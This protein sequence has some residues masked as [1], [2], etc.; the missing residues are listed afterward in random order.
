M[1]RGIASRRLRLHLVCGKGL[2]HKWESFSRKA[3]HQRG[4]SSAAAL[5]RSSHFRPFPFSFLPLRP[6]LS[7]FLERK[8]GGREEKSECFFFFFFPIFI[9]P[10]FR[11]LFAAFLLLN[12]KTAVLWEKARCAW[13]KAPMRGAFFSSF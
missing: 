13:E 6:S 10:F 2:R 12:T 5:F 8:P 1:G 11:S 4:A 3:A 9:Y 7:F